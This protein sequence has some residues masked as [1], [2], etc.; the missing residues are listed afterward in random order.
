MKISQI[1]NHRK[2]TIIEYL[3]LQQ[4]SQGYTNSHT[5]KQTNKYPKQ[6][7]PIPKTVTKSAN[8][9]EIHTIQL[10]YRNNE[11]SDRAIRGEEV[12]SDSWGGEDSGLLR[13]RKCNALIAE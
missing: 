1:H 12:Q 2:T 9:D 10:Q 5:D 6:K 4:I 7:S 3:N 13:E 11:Q 8:P